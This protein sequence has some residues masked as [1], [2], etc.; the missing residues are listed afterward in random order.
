MFST[1]SFSELR[2]H[3]ELNHNDIYSVEQIDKMIS[4]FYHKSEDT[5]ASIQMEPN[6]YHSFIEQS[7]QK[8]DQNLRKPNEYSKTQTI[9]SQ[10]SQQLN[11]IIIPITID[12]EDEWFWNKGYN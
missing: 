9:N 3:L 8:C 2:Q 11:E 1:N 4:S 10:Q 5:V 12:S 7:I 6:K